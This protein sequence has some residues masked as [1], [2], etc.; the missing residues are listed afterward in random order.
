MAQPPSD[1]CLPQA[2]S[3][4]TGSPG[5]GA[6]TESTGRA[7]DL[8]LKLSVGNHRRTTFFAGSIPKSFWE[9]YV[10]RSDSRF[11][12]AFETVGVVWKVVVCSK[13]DRIRVMSGR[14]LHILWPAARYM[15]TTV[16]ATHHNLPHN[17]RRL[18]CEFESAVRALHV[19]FPETLWDALHETNNSF[20]LLSSM[21]VGFEFEVLSPKTQITWDLR[22]GAS[23]AQGRTTKPSMKGVFQIAYSRL[24]SR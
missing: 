12:F 7:P 21:K 14:S 16:L 5:D 1:S 18:E 19:R 2:G 24:R 3:P 10:K 8:E 11:K 15:D 4:P 22:S 13:N 23:E 17:P 20:L 6:A 9:T